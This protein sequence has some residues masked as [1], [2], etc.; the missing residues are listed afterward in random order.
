[1]IDAVRPITILIADDDAEDRDLAQR[2]LRA[3]RLDND[4]RFVSDG[5]ELMDYLFRRGR[6]E[7]AA[8]SPRPG[9]LLLDL[10]M[11]K[12]DGLSCLKELRANAE[13]RALPVVMLTTSSAEKDVF[14]SYDLGVNSYITK[15]VTFSGLVDAMRAIGHYWFRIVELPAEVSK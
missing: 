7:D 13:L 15:P 2:G 5:D 9:L 14:D 12:R 10:Q 6:Y 4:L 8:T 3:A 1:M 11:P